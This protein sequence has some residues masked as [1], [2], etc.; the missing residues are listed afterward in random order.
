MFKTPQ[1]QHGLSSRKTKERK[2]TALTTTKY[3]FSCFILINKMFLF[4][5]LNRRQQ[6]VKEKL[7]LGT[8]GE[9]KIIIKS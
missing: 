2:N 9:G 8:F 6:K 5:I 1:N 3:S 7:L 4:L